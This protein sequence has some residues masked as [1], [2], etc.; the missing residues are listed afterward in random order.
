[1]IQNTEKHIT[2][3]EVAAIE[4]RL[5]V[6]IKN[7]NKHFS[8]VFKAKP[9]ISISLNNGGLL[10]YHGSLFISGYYFEGNINIT[11][12]LVCHASGGYLTKR[13]I[14]LD[15]ASTMTAFQIEREVK[16]AVKAEMSFTKNEREVHKKA[17]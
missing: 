17:S 12:G 7:A 10:K 15:D 16:K 3:K 8:N 13:Y 2:K 1:M 4:K 9:Y 5:K 14:T 11:F 6:A